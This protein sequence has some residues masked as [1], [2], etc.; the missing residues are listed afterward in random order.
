MT[1]YKLTEKEKENLILISI[2]NIIIEEPDSE[3]A[4][5]LKELFE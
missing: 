5:F 3:F 1:T 4:K 2:H